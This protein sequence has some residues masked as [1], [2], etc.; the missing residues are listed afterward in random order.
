MHADHQE[1]EIDEI[2]GEAQPDQS[3]PRLARQ[4]RRHPTPARRDQQSRDQAIGE[5]TP[6][7]QQQGRGLGHDLGR[8][9]DQPPQSARRQTAGDAPETRRGRHYSA[10]GSTIRPPV[11]GAGTPVVPG[12]LTGRP[13]RQRAARKAKASAS[14]ESPRQPLFSAVETGTPT[15]SR[16]AASNTGLWRPPPQTTISLGCSEQRAT[17]NATACAAKAVRVAAASS[18]DKLATG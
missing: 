1:G 2:P 12:K 15:R 7:R 13:R 11:M 16:M 9:E 10:P 17:P 8:Q 18:S 3:A 14:I 6:R 5:V 4:G